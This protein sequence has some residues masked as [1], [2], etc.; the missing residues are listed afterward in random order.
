MLTQAVFCLVV[1][2]AMPA[3]A[4]WT[5]RQF[6]VP[7]AVVSYFPVDGENIDIRVTGDWG[8]PYA[9]TRAK[10]ERMTRETIE[11]LQ[12]GSRF[13]GYKNPA[14]KPALIY[15]V[16]ATFEFK[17][18]LPTCPLQAGEGAPMTDYNAIMREIDIQ[19][20]V[21]RKGVKQIW[22]WGYHGGKVGLWESNMASPSGDVSNS[23]RNPSDLPILGRT[24]TVFHYNYQ[25]GT[26][27]AVEDH[28]HQLEA[29]LNYVDGRDR[30]PPE[31][32]PDLLFWGKFVGSDRS[33]K[34]VSTPARCGWTHY[35]P[36]SDG[37]YD[38][39][40]KRYVETDIEDWRPDA[41]GETQRLNCDRWG[42]DGLK[43]KIYWMRAIPGL[44]NGLTYRG[45]PLTNWWA[46]VGD[47]DRCM[48]EKTAL[49]V[50]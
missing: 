38:W 43:W 48:R 34:I 29:L 7:V 24:Y 25:R 46:F 31:Q 20:L 13:R 33:H 5:Q 26:G 28:T 35:A 30:T 1:A 3:R 18:P 11:A 40:N 2:S 6:T 16:A 32:W 4:D 47:W 39:A 23:S 37:D 17:K 44:R 50:R 19:D 10:C 49:T 45:K 27:E 21:E 15:K 42:G 9:E 36:N 8:R 12:E 14:A 41:P 22:I